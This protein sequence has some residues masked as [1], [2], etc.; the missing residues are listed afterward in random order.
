[1]CSS[2]LVAVPGTGAYCQPLSSNYNLTPRPGVLAVRAGRADW[3]IRPETH[4]DLLA[5]D[6]GPIDS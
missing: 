3:L 4:D 6:C 1:M 5:R 2:D